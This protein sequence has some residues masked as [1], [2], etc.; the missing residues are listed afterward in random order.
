MTSASAAGFWGKIKT[1]E[2]MVMICILLADFGSIF[3]NAA[4]G[5]AVFEN[6]LIYIALIL[7]IVSLMDYLIHNKGVLAENNK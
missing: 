3:P 2:Q 4:D 6:V 5:I 7:T 1:A